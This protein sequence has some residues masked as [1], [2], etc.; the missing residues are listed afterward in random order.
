MF[1]SRAR[2][3]D[4]PRSLFINSLDYALL[5]SGSQFTVGVV[6]GG[7][8]RQAPMATELHQQFPS[9]PTLLLNTPVL[10]MLARTVMSK[11]AVAVAVMLEPPVT[12]IITPTASTTLPEFSV[13][14]INNSRPLMVKE[15]FQSLAIMDPIPVF[16]GVVDTAIE[17]AKAFYPR[18][19]LISK[20][21]DLPLRMVRTAGFSN[22]LS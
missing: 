2:I 16:P 5:W 13:V 18:W 20:L 3:H 7:H 6:D 4:A 1:T 8:L 9:V 10:T 17:D 15:S 14:K 19:G 21:A 11:P 22:P 12:S